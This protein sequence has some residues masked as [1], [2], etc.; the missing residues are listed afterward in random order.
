VIDAIVPARNEQLTVADVVGACRQCQAVREVIVVDD[1]ST[2]E[3]VERALAAGAKVV[4]RGGPL[5]PLAGSKAHAMAAGAA[6]SDAQAF[7]FV[8]ADLLG[9]T[10]AHLDDICR[11]Y[12][13]GRAVMSLGWFDYGVWNPLVLRLPPT[14]GERVVPRWVFEAVPPSRRDGYTI[15][16]MITEVVAKGRLPTTARIMK[17]VSHR[18]KRDKFGILEGYRRTW[19]MFCDLIELPLRGVVQWRTYWSYLRGLRV[20]TERAASGMSTAARRRG[21]GRRGRPPGYVRVDGAACSQSRRAMTLSASVSSA[22]SKMERTL[23]STK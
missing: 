4:Q 17:G 14:T 15:E 6:A 22:P 10:A 19:D 18:T 21:I 23:A 20:E 9:L 8:D 13:E 7:L 16:F 2:D 12:I 3:T 5:A 1:G 11:P